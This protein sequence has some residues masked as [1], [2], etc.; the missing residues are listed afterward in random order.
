VHVVVVTVS[1]LTIN[2]GERFDLSKINALADD[3]D[4]FMF[5]VVVGVVLMVVVMMMMLLLLMMMMMTKMI[6]ARP[7]ISTRLQTHQHIP[8]QNDKA[9]AI[10]RPK[11]RRCNVSVI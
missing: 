10:T 4:R 2:S 9:A 11:P 1:S 3:N 8:F 6:H 7:P 5:V